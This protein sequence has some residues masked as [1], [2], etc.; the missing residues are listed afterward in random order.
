MGRELDIG[1]WDGI[2]EFKWRISFSFV[3]GVVLNLQKLH[4]VEYG[5]RQ[6]I[7]AFAFLGVVFL[8]QVDAHVL[9]KG[10]KI[11]ANQD[12]HV[13]VAQQEHVR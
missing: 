7:V 12:R 5:G 4:G 3:L 6:G 8:L 10:H 11:F 13:V 1:G 2:E 9:F